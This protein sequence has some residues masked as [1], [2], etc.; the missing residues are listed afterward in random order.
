MRYSWTGN[1][2]LIDQSMHKWWSEKI[3]NPHK[4][5]NPFPA[6]KTKTLF[7]ALVESY[8]RRLQV[9]SITFAFFFR[10]S[11]VADT[12]FATTLY[13]LPIFFVLFF[14]HFHSSAVLDKVRSEGGGGVVEVR[15]LQTLTAA[16]FVQLSVLG[17]GTWRDGETRCVCMCVACVW[18][19]LDIVNTCFREDYLV[20]RFVERLLFKCLRKLKT[21]GPSAWRRVPWRRRRN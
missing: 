11:Y 16:T 13:P 12:P 20:N 17:E 1:G 8:Q 5:P 21:N 3:R 18:H 4:P 2:N 7:K 19:G 9:S 14:H 6:K 10:S 15:L